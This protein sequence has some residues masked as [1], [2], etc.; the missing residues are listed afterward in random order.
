MKN[1]CI[2]FW[3]VLFALVLYGC[4]SR[5]NADRI[6]EGQAVIEA[7]QLELPTD[8]GSEKDT[9]I[10]EPTNTPVPID[11]PVIVVDTGSDAVPFLSEL[12]ASN[13][14]TLLDEPLNV[15]Y[16][17]IYFALHYINRSLEVCDT[18]IGYEI[19]DG[20][21][22]RYLLVQDFKFINEDN[23][24]FLDFAEG[25]HGIYGFKL[26]YSYPRSSKYA[27]GLVIDTYFDKGKRIADGITFSWNESIKQ[28]EEI[29]F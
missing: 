15:N 25:Y 24:V 7:P 26:M 9:I 13:E 1:I 23:S 10:R 12:F 20:V 5:K 19:I 22:H 28:F 16:R 2:F 6:T 4:D 14:Y 21:F 3:L 11:T 17:N 27:P 8:L 18:I 29:R